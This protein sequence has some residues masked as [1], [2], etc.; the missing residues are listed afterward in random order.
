MGGK[1]FELIEAD[2][3]MIPNAAL[4]GSHHVVVLN[5][6]ALEDARFAVIHL[7]RKMH[8][9]LVLGFCEDP[10]HMHWKADQFGGLLHVALDDF[11]KCE[12]VSSHRPRCYTAGGWQAQILRIK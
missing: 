3:L 11:E 12:L 1:R 7:H 6:I 4:V 9:Q 8:D 5:P 10:L 2:L